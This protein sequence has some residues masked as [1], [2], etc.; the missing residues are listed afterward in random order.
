MKK[1]VLLAL[2]LVFNSIS[3]GDELTFVADEWPPFNGVPGSDYEGYMVDVARAVFEPLGH[4]V[5]Y[6]VIPWN[7]AII[8]T[9]EGRYTA[10]IGASR[11]NAPDFIYPEE[12][13]NRN[14]L[15]FYTHKYSDWVFDGIQSLKSVRIATVKDYDYRDWFRAFEQTNP[16]NVDIAFGDKPLITNI[17]KMVNG[18][19]DVVVDNQPAIIWSA[20]SADLLDQIRFAGK[21]TIGGESYIYHAFSPAN[22]KSQAYADTLSKGIIHLRESGELQKILDRYNL[23]DWK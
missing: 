4:T 2:L 9:R 10:I 23:P 3:H 17:V 1:T 13:L 11:P 5:S 20:K 14:V 12:E 16:E 22:P 6:L 21:D 18:R 7:R 19:V 8:D 15:V